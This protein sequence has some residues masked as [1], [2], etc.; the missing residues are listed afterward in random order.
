MSPI[1]YSPSV[2]QIPEDEPETIE[3]LKEQF[4]KLADLQQ[5]EE[6]LGFIAS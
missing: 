6:G 5:K 2:E 3:S 4:F 1:R